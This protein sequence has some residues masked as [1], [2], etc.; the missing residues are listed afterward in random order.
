MCSHTHLAEVVGQIFGHPFGE[1]R[2]E[3]TL[4]VCHASFDFAEQI[5]DL[6]LGWSH[7][8]HR[9]EEASRTNDLLNNLL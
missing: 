7:M 5:V 2:D 6:S 4:F 3:Y 9:V 1:G 8:D